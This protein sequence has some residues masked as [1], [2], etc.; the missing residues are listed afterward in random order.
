MLTYVKVHLNVCLLD[1]FCSYY[2][3]QTMEIITHLLRD[4]YLVQ[5]HEHC[6]L[7]LKA[8]FM[9]TWVHYNIRKKYAFN[10]V[11]LKEKMG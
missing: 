2:V 4:S 1:A 8:N 5:Q 6:E 11:A 10:M 7:E 3:E 9:L